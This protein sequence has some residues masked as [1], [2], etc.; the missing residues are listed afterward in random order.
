[1]KLRLSRWRNS[2]GSSMVMRWSA[3]L[4]LMRSIIAASVVDLPEPVVPVTRTRPRCSSQIL[5]MTL[6]RLSSST[7][8]L[9]GNDAENH[10]DVAT[11]LEN[12]DTETAETGDAVG[13]VEL[14]GFLELL[15][16][17][18]GHHAERHGKHF[19]GSDAGDFGDGRQKAVNAEIRVIAD[20]EVQVRRFVF[21]GSPEKIVNT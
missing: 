13:H 15:F 17:A 4:A 16:L 18:V 11:L 9:C 12:V 14:G 3:R 6:G 2:I 5:L 20:F 8:N 19:F 21:D 1:M 7:V 10:T